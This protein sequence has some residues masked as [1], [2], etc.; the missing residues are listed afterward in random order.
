MTMAGSRI[1]PTPADQFNHCVVALKMPGGEYVMYDP[2]WAPFSRARWSFLETEQHYLIGSPEGESLNQIRYSPPA[3]SPLDI[4]SRC[5]L[6]ADGSLTGTIELTADGAMDGYLRRLVSWFSLEEREDYLLRML[7]N[8]SDGIILDR[9]QHGDILDFHDRMWWKIEYRVP[10]YALVVDSA[11]EFKSPMMQLTKDNRILFRAGSREWPEKRHDDLFM[12]YTQHLNGTE[13]VT[14][15][16]HY[17]VHD[18]PKA[19]KIDTTYAY[20]HGVS[21][22]DD[23]KLSVSQQVK[24]KRRQIPPEGYGGFRTAMN[25][26]RDFAETRFRATKGGKK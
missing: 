4:T 12:Y 7:A 5:A 19:E 11:L 20:F 24:L 15:P 1:E 3:E 16:K 13:T 10:D 22:M 26:A 25:E 21:K 14:L 17:E 9:Y 18:P 23:S 2:T 8:I 6:K